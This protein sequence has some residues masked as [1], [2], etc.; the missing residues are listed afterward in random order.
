MKAGADIKKGQTVVKKGQR[1]G[2]REISAI[3]AVGKAK[4]KVYKVSQSGNS[5]HWRRNNRAR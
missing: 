3:A 1:I 4:V 2:A 5:I